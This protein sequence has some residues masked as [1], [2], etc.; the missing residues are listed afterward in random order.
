M[1]G[2]PPVVDWAGPFRLWPQIENKPKDVMASLHRPQN[3]NPT[4]TLHALLMKTPTVRRLELV[5]GEGRCRS[6]HLIHLASVGYL[7]L[8][9]VWLA[10]SLPAD[11]SQRLLEPF[12][13]FERAFPGIGGVAK[14]RALAIIR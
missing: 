8:R 5:V 10:S 3:Q 2:A 6:K 12:V 9:A 13:G 14:D 1:G 7:S 11:D 4:Q